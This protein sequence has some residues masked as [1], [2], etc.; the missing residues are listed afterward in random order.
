MDWQRWMLAQDIREIAVRYAGGVPEELKVEVG[1]HQR[2]S[3]SCF[4][5]VLVMDRQTDEVRQES[6][7]RKT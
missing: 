1:L 5:F 3:S 7:V 2:S 4:L 6:A